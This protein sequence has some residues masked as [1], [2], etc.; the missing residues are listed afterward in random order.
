MAFLTG[1]LAVVTC[2][3]HVLILVTLLSGTAAGAFLSE[4]IVLAAFLLLV[5]SIASA[6]VMSRLLEDDESRNTKG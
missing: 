2:P 3:C 5:V 4:N 1:T 6:T